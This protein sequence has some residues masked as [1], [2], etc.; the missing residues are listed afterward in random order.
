MF[1]FAV[2][3]GVAWHKLCLKQPWTSWQKGHCHAN[4]IQ[5]LLPKGVRPAWSCKKKM[6]AWD[7][8]SACWLV[9]TPMFFGKYMTF[10]FAYTT[11]PLGKGSIQSFWWKILGMVVVFFFCFEVCSWETNGTPCQKG[12]KSIKANIT[13]NMFSFILNIIWYSVSCIAGCANF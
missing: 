12:F 2:V 7:W 10:S 6:W 11:I 8:V 9:Y 5:N 4:R 1:V 3:H 13:I